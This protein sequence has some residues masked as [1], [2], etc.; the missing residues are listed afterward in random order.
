M[1]LTAIIAL[2]FALLRAAGPVVSIFQFPPFLLMIV[3]LDLALVQAVAFG[4]PLRTF[5]FTFLIV[6]VVSTGVITALCVRESRPPWLSLHIL[7]TAIQHYRAVRGESRGISPYT[8]FPMLAEAERWVTC[9]LSLLP[10][11]AAAVLASRWMRR[12]C[13]RKSGW[14][15]TVTAFLQGALIGLG[16]MA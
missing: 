13:L 10:P 15:Q 2:N 6:G 4:R 1:K 12:R 16:R 14:G 5:Y 11:L 7:E 9:I 8:E 3:L